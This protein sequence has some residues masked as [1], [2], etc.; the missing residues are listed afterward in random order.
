M[1][2]DPSIYNIADMVNEVIKQ[3]IP[4]ESSETLAIGPFGYMA[5]IHS[6]Q[7]QNDIIIGSELGNELWPS[8]ARFEKNVI[9]HAIVQNITDINAVPAHMISYLGLYEDQIESL[10]SADKFVI[11]KDAKIAIGKFEFHLDYDIIL[12]RTKI[13]NNQYVYSARYDI[14]RKNYSSDI[15][16]PYLAAPFS[17]VEQTRRIVYIP[18]RITQVEH[19]TVYKKIIT[20]NI[21]DNKSFEFDFE[22]QLVDFDICVI[23]NDKET[24][25]RPVLEGTGVQ[26]D[27]KDF[28]YYTYIDSQN[29][30][31][32]FDSISYLPSLN[33]EIEVYIKTTHGA[34]GNFEYGSVLQK[35]LSSSKYGYNIDFIIRFGSNS[36][37]GEDRK[38]IDDLRKELPKEALSRGSV[39][40]SQDL[41]NKFNMLQKED[42]R[43]KVLDK[44]DNQF[45]RSYYCYLILKDSNGN[46]IPTNTINLMVKRTDFDIHDNRKYILKT[47]CA[48]VLKG[49]FAY[50][51]PRDSAE[52]VE[53]EK[54]N[55]HN[56]IYTLPFTM[57]VN[58]DPLYVSYYLTLMNTL[59]YLNFDY[60]NQ[61]SRMQFISTGIAW[62]RQYLTDPEYYTMSITVS[63]SLVFDNVSDS[64]ISGDV[65]DKIKII[66]VLYNED[67]TSPYRYVEGHYKQKVQSGY[68]FEF[69]LKTTDQIDDYNRIRIENL[70]I[71]GSSSFDYGYFTGHFNMNIYVLFNDSKGEFGRYDLDNIV[72]GLEGWT[73]TNMYSVVNGLYFFYNYSRIITSHTRDARLEGV[74]DD[75]AFAIKSVPVLKRSYVQ[76]EESRIQTFIDKL[77]YHKAYIDYIMNLL[78]NFLIDFKFYNTYG[79]AIEYSTDK[80]GENVIDRI[81]LSL[82]F[83]LKL[84]KTSDSLTKDYILKDVK[85]IIEDLNDMDSLHIPNLITTITTKYRD[86]I[87]Y[88]EFIGFNGYGP[89][90]QHLYRIEREDVTV[91]PEFLTV[92]MLDDMTPDIEIRL[93]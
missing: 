23:E 49:D 73:V 27:I 75:Q 14:S 3:Y 50:V 72:P 36:E 11:D 46:I 43:I 88:F 19:T 22:N 83:D 33:A 90:V 20:N 17:Q 67:S 13:V 21:I 34:E 2:I 84:L 28:C 10:F 93:V 48:L 41:Q 35:N 31:I 63:P 55:T 61:D 78:N 56:F 51:Y 40:N 76:Y 44:V 54:D 82:I 62:S 4:E 58:M 52:L 12:S 66:A 1:S 7:I 68:V 16:N 32:K 65:H 60:I 71:P 5:D 29:I 42:S 69:K 47:G 86:S 89:G 24:W 39:S 70:G 87:E 9:A 45:E 26:N 18:C 64:D 85:D 15:S 37:G 91:V 74:Y 92:N 25:L 53:L 77:N 80:L 30:K 59:S 57:V 81:H 38:S 79:P 8:R 6:T